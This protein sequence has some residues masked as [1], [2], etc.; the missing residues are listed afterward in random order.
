MNEIIVLTYFDFSLLLFVL[1][2]ILLSMLMINSYI[3]KL[4]KNNKHMAKNIKFLNKMRMKNEFELY[5]FTTLASVNESKIKGAIANFN[6]ELFV[7]HSASC[8]GTM[9][10]LFVDFLEKASK[11]EIEALM[12]RYND[13]KHTVLMGILETFRNSKS[14]EKAPVKKT[15]KKKKTTKKKKTSK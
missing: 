4:K 11:K 3:K 8:A 14:E 7:A 2:S 6:R 9:D 13:S 5:K 10:I 12:E 1:A 15:V